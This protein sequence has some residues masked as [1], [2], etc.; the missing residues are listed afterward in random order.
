M[1]QQVSVLYILKCAQGQERLF[2][3]LGEESIN[4]YRMDMIRA[5]MNRGRL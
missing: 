4:N 3:S 5:I 2:K 1:I